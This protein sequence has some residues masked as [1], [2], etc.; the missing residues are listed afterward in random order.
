MKILEIEMTTNVVFTTEQM[1]SANPT[2]T[3]EKQ[4]R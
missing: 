3:T 1:S 2:T 4:S